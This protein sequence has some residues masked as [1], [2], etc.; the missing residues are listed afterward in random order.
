[1]TRIGGF[2]T[3]RILLVVLILRGAGLAGEA[4]ERA[5]LAPVTRE[6]AAALP[7]VTRG[8]A[9]GLAPVTGGRAAGLVPV[10][11][12]R[13]AS[14]PPAVRER[15][16]Q[17]APVTSDRAARL[18]PVTRGRAARLAPVTRDRAAS[19][20]PV[21]AGRAAGLE[22]VTDG[23]APVTTGRVAGLAPVT[24]GR[25]AGLEPV[26]DGLPPVTSGR[27]AAP[28]PVTG[29]PDPPEA[30]VAPERAA[31]ELSEGF[32]ERAARTG[33]PLLLGEEALR[34]GRYR[35]AEYAFTEGVL[36]RPDSP[37]ARFAL[38]DACMALGEWRRAEAHVREGLRLAS[39]WGEAGSVPALAAESAERGG[40]SPFLVGWLRYGAGERVAAARCFGQALRTDPHDDA[41]AAMLLR[42]SEE[43]APAR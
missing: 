14:L 39:R 18:L 4:P 3:L 42:I 10:A 6:R 23:L 20:A 26:T 34:R 40:A 1:M 19:L 13:A 24:S 8:R 15:A 28:P 29:D 36:R 12:D 32:A 11:G 2:R 16:A 33:F 38:A 25:T 37:L 41:A 17:L 9:A 22:P 35:D 21:S 30:V 5:G 27:A 31:Q 43:M 7:P